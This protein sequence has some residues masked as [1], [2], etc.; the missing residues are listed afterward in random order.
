M[1]AMS[2]P[3]GQAALQGAVFSSYLGWKNRHEPVLFTAVVELEDDGAVLR[4]SLLLTP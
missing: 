1:R 3:T 4:R 2:C